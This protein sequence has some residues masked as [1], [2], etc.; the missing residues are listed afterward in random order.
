LLLRSSRALQRYMP[1]LVGLFMSALVGYSL[2][3]LNIVPGLSIL[4][5]PISAITGKDMSF[6]G[7]T[8]IW[9]I[10]SDHIK[11][12]PLFG[13]GYGAYW[14]GPA[15]ES[16][17]YEFVRLL[18]FYPG[19]AH[20]GYLEMLNDLGALGLL[21]LFAYLISFVRQS[22]RLLHKDRLQASLFLA[23]FLQQAIVNLSESRW[24]SVFSVDFVIMTLAT[25][26]LARALLEQS[27]RSPS[28]T[29]QAA[30]TRTTPV[31]DL[32]RRYAAQRPS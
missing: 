13:S 5:S 7:R 20:N 14:T 8:E 18:N 25:A 11:L 22:L 30:D 2:V 4:M 3:V 10:V 17:S 24:L 29:R 1:Y 16:P 6:T 19:S 9:D 12:Q 31:A 28:G 32:S 27:L 15:P 21:V 26:A 23:L